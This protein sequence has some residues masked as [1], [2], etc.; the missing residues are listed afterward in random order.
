MDPTCSTMGKSD[1][2]AWEATPSEVKGA[3]TLCGVCAPGV[4]AL[5]KPDVAQS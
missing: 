3:Y 4:T 5:E 2:K 1:R